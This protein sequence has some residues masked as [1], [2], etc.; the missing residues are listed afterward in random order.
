MKTILVVEDEPDLGQILQDELIKAKF[1]VLLAKDGV[2][3]LSLA[4]KHKPDLIV[5]DILMPK[6][7]GITMVKTLHNDA[8]GKDIPIM[9]LSNLSD[10]DIIS[11][12]L[13]NK[14]YDY[15]VKSDWELDEVIKKIQ[16][17]L[18]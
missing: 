4:L 10:P 5:V 16:A 6:M 8:V 3:G 18:E 17:K 2:E 14:V 9:V 12:A 13:D 11:K 1:K 7:D 15:I